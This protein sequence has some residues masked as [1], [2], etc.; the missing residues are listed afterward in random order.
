MSEVGPQGP[1]FPAPQSLR[2]A[3]RRDRELAAYAEAACVQVRHMIDLPELTA[4]KDM[5]SH[6]TISELADECVTRLLAVGTTNSEWAL[7]L[8][9]LVFDLY[10]LNLKLFEQEYAR[11]EARLG[12]CAA[13]LRR[14]GHLPSSADLLD[15]A[16][17]ELVATAGFGRAGISRL[18]AKAWRPAAGYFTGGEKY[19]AWWSE[20][21]N[22]PVPLEESTPEVAAIIDHRPI[23]VHDATSTYRP[24]AQSSRLASYVVAPVKFGSDVVG[25]VHADMHPLGR[26]VDV[27]DGETLA[28][29]VDGFSRLFERFV[30]T[31]RLRDQSALAH[32]ILSDVGRAFGDIGDFTA[33]L[34]AHYSGA[35]AT[36]RVAGIPAGVD[37]LTSRESE[38]FDLLVSGASNSAIAKRLVISEDTV[39]SHVKQILRKVGVSNRAQAISMAL[40]PSQARHCRSTDPGGLSRDRG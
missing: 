5:S 26:G 29:F 36:D 35:M 20:W 13:G 19:N 9:E 32:G 22:Q 24:I 40:A 33:D 37:Q 21:V 14:L 12:E 31:E 4:G 6:A 17:R 38:V 7:R 8:C 25:F 28:T 11:R 10:E 34:R 1:L 23:V 39:K 15:Q 3:K 18:E 16:C 27:F 30:L 2:G